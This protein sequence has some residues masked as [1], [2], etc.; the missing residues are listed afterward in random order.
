MLHPFFCDV[1]SY[2]VVYTVLVGVLHIWSIFSARGR[3]LGKTDIFP[4]VDIA[5]ICVI[6][7][8]CN[9]RSVTA[10]SNGVIL[11]RCHG[12]NVRPAADV[13]LTGV[14]PSRGNYSP[15]T[16]QPHG[17]CEYPAARA[18]MSVQLL[19]LH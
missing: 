17:V 1:F 15:V 2:V 11:S 18:T 16:A 6:P 3:L 13:T 14:I 12:R 5:L 9:H 8:R 19:T 10:Q 7:P 4:V